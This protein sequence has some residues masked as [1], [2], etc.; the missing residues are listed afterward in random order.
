MDVALS[1][2]GSANEKEKHF[3]NALSP[4]TAGWVIPGSRALGEKFT[5]SIYK[6]DDDIPA[7][8]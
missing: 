3:Q 8:D 2:F 4:L 7:M 5:R 6:D 1:M